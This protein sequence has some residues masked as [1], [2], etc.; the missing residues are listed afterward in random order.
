MLNVNV[1][2]IQNS[3]LDYVGCLN[4]NVELQKNVIL[5]NVSNECQF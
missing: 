2:I 3:S 1:H 5:V 4:V